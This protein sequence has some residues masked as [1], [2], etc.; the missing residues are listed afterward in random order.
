MDATTD[1]SPSGLAS[2]FFGGPAAD[3]AGRDMSPSGL[4]EMFQFPVGSIAH[5]TFGLLRL[6]KLL[7]K[8]HTVW[9]GRDQC[10]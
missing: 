1:V 9:M 10:R 2:W 3:A 7:S 5:L 8:F 6:L 4:S